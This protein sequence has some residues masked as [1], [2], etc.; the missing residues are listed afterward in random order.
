AKPQPRV[1][2]PRFGVDWKSCKTPMQAGPGWNGRIF[3][4][5]VITQ[6]GTIENARVISENTPQEIIDAALAAVTSCQAQPAIVDAAPVD[7]PDRASFM[8]GAGNAPPQIF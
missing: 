4:D 6:K 2:P 5:F 3:V 8:F 1:T 7:T